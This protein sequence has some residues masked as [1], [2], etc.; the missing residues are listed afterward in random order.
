MFINKKL[1]LLALLILSQLVGWT[2][3][4]DVNAAFTTSQ[5]DICGPGPTTINFTNNSTGVNAA[6]ADY[7]WFLNGSSIDN[8][9]GLAAPNSDNI[10]AVGTYTYM[11][12]ATDA[13]VPC[14]DTAIMVVNIYPTPSAGFNFG[15]NNAC[16]GTTVNFNN[17]STGTQGSTTYNWNFGDGN[18]STQQNPSNNYAAGGTY[19][20]NLTVTNGPGCTSSTSQIVTALDIPNVNISGDDGDGDLTNCLLP[21]DPSTQETVTFFNSTTDAVSYEWD[22]GDGSPVFTTGSSA[23]FTHDYTSFGTYT[24]TMTATHANGC[25]STA[26]LTVV[27]EKYVSAAM[28]LDITEYSGCAPHTMSTLTN[29]SVNA[30]SYVWDFGDGSVITTTSP[31]PPAHAYT[32]AGTYTISLT[33]I[34]SCN[35]ANATI[36]PIVII[37]GPTANFGTNLP[38]SGGTLG[39][40]PHN[41]T[42]TN[43]STNAQPANNFYWDMGN[44][45]TYTNT[46]TPPAQAYDTAGTYT[47]MLVAQNACGP[48][49]LIMSVTLDT[50]PVVDIVSTPLDG[51][52]PLT[53]QTTNNSYVHPMNYQWFVDGVFTSTN[54]NLPDQTFI[55]SGTNAPVNHTIQLNGSNICGNDSDLE[56]IVVHPETIAN[57]NLSATEICVGESITFTSTSTGEALTYDWDFVTQTEATQGPHTVTYNVAGNYT[58]TLIVDGFC[59]PDTATADIIVHPFPIADFTANPTSGCVN[60]DVNITNNSTLGGTYNWIFNGATPGTSNLY[61]PP[62]LNY[63]TA[64][65]YD[66]VLQVNVNGCIANDT[67][68]IIANP[69]PIPSFTVTPNNGCTPLDV[70]FTNTSPNNPGDV[71]DWDLGN[72]N[73]FNG[74][75][76]PNQTYVAAANDSIYTVQLIITT[77]DGCVDS[78]ETNVTVHPLPIADY[79]P[80]PDTACALDPIAFLNNSTGGSTYEWDFGDGTFST[81]ISPSHSY[82]LT[83]DISTQL[84]VTTAFGCTDTMTYDIYVDSIP[85]ADFNFTVVCDIDTTSFT[86]LSTGSPTVWEWDFGDGSPV[87][88]NENPTHFYGAAGNYNVILTVTNPAGC[89]ATTN[90]LVAVSE[91]PIADFITNPTCLGSLSQFTDNSSGIPTTWIWDFGDGSPV[92]NNQNPT[93][94][95]ATTGTYTVELITMA[96]N[97][98][99][100][101]TSLPITV[102]PIPTADFTFVEVCTNDT[103]FFTDASLGAPDTWEWNFGDGN[104]DLTNNPNPAHVYTTAGTYNVMLVAGYSASGCTD[105]IVYS[106]EA[107]PLTTPNF[108]T[109]TPCLGGTTIF[110]DLTGGTPT[111]WEWN[112]GDGSAV[113]NTQ[114][115]SHNYLTP[116][117]FDVQL[118][119]ENVFGCIDTIITSVEVFPLPT[120]D[121]EFDT[122][123]LNALTS[124]TDLSIDA[125]AWEWDFGDGS[126]FS[127]T[128][129]P[130]HVYGT[131]GTFDVQLVVT[132][133]QGCTDTS[134][135]TITVNPNPFADYTFSVACHTYPTVFT[136]NSSGSLNYYWDFGDGT[137]INNNA[138]PS[139]TYANDGS[140]DVEMIVENVFGCTDTIIQTVDVLVQPQAGFVNNTVCAGESVAF[141]DTSTLGPTT[142]EWDFGDG[143]PLDNNQNPS[144]LFNPGG[145]YNVTLIVGNI[146]GCMDTTVVP[147]EVFTVPVPNFTAD[148][149]CLFSITSFTDLT[150][151]ATPLA[152]WDWDFDDGNTSFQQNPTYI[153]QSPGQYDVEL[154]V[155]NVN[156]CDSSI[157]LPV[158]VSDIPVAQFIA[159]TV[160]LGNPTTFTD[161]SSGFPSSWIW[162][163]GDGNSSSIGPVVQHTYAGPGTYIA[164][165]FVTAGGA[166]SDQVFQIVEVVDN[167]QAGIIAQ[168]S[169]CDGNTVNFIDDSNIL[170]GTISDYFWDFGD[171][172]SA[173]TQ[174]ASHLYGAPGTY[175]VIHTVQTTGGCSNS[176]TMDITVLDVPVTNFLDLQGCQNAPVSFADQSTIANGAIVSW[177]WDFGD[178]SPVMTSQNPTHIFT[179]DGTFTVNLTVTSEFGC[180]SSVDIPIVVHPAPVAAFTA[181]IACPGDTIQFTDL[182]SIS[183]GSIVN[184]EWDFDD[185]TQSFVQHPQHA[186]QD[187]VDNFDVSLIVTSNF[188]CTD[189]VIQNV[190]THPFPTFLYGPN[191]AAGCQPLEMQFHDSSIVAGGIITN[192]EWNFDDGSASFAEDP[193]HIFDEPGEYYVSLSLTTSDGCTFTNDLSYPVVV[194]P[195]PEAGFSPIHSEVSILEPEVQFI[196]NSYGTLDWEWYFGDGNYSNESNPLHEYNDTGYFEVMQIVYSD[197]GCSDTAYGTVHVYGV[198]S[199]YVPN[200]F[201]PNGDSKNGTFRA[202]GM[203]ID[204]YDMWIFNRWGE[205][206]WHTQDINS[207]W[208]GTYNGILVKDDVY[209]WKIVCYDTEGGE[210]ELYGHVTV[211]K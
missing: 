145:I 189:T 130:T 7:E 57:F 159:D 40:A 50:L 21:A 129:N 33:A 155:T 141:T 20:V 162:T 135:Q 100:D 70:S 61:S 138:S 194:Y 127:F 25:T 176:T 192:W 90:Q 133:V 132:N 198:F 95:Y 195:K 123:C 30:N 197:F 18:T 164:S 39:C 38:F 175:N 120:A 42:V 169:I 203:A 68:A 98:C 4:A 85:T 55:N 158:F 72:G 110:T 160:C 174:D 148:T 91:V 19:N 142:W 153:F 207:S 166:C 81:A 179:S 167:V 96:G 208:D 111:I 112:F 46:T 24:V 94:I 113:D 191:F 88:N 12:V 121:F 22:F 199:V 185:S 122:V 150:V 75:N 154:I 124:F 43:S 69:L 11:L 144:H 84:V 17:T 8:T 131:S 146:A 156:G 23:P 67:V 76:P 15:P 14:T 205:Q 60:F 140:Y 47:V 126:A 44:G 99:S 5:T 178:G 186:F 128:Q 27:F 165:L 56:T 82:T 183:S 187:L 103:T 64:G 79:T 172:N 32:T 171:G 54:Q 109:N 137:A 193:I 93:H 161:A 209:V 6:A 211:L 86:D 58:I 36:S 45:N 87:D 105:T 16:A 134:I 170:I 53:V 136:D 117:L 149:V 173:T 125:V 31:T 106:V 2:Q 182:S 157:I 101:T 200:T 190:Q 78:V 73:T 188:G 89:T 63:A 115:P 163:F 102:T 13:S 65:S 59:G 48:D 206:V 80:L 28:T 139:Y 92:D 152:S 184:W 201:T 116:G 202:Y 71:F 151:D 77:A 210:H 1:L 143:S 3:C 10:G 51:C 97:G 118:V 107:N 35:M 49:T 119:T 26:T 114:N 177:T 66:I 196:D 9:S 41:F 180:S 37:D 29:L 147:V 52:S 62:T 181:P 104:T 34:N 74:Q 168:D 108:S 204:T 83:G